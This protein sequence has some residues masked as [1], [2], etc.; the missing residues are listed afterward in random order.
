[1][2]L[3]PNGTV[4]VVTTC[5]ESDDKDNPSDDGTNDAQEKSNEQGNNDDEVKQKTGGELIQYSYSGNKLLESTLDECPDSI[6]IVSLVD[7]ICLALSY[8]WV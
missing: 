1:M 3:L 4:A 8:R 5:R 7:R 6:T 2:T